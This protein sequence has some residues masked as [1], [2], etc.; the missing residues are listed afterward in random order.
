MTQTRTRNASSVASKALATARNNRASSTTN[1]TKVDSNVD[2]KESELTGSYLL[3]EFMEKYSVELVPEF[4]INVNNYPFLTFVEP[5]NDNNTK[6]NAYLS[7]KASD[8]MRELDEKGKPT[9]DYIFGHK[10]AIGFDF[11][12]EY[13]LKIYQYV[14]KATGEERFKVGLK[15]GEGKS[16]WLKAK[17]VKD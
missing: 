10:E 3:S 12:Y 1:S 6:V 11:F 13:S 7:I 5:D 14:D 9:E 2:E 16:T 15:Q 17:D 8:S 4:R